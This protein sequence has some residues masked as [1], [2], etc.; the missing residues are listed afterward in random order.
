MVDPDVIPAGIDPEL[1]HF[2]T[3]APIRNLF[4]DRL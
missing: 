3:W 1:E 4:W 2:R